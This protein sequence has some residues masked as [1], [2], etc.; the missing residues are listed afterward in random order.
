VSIGRAPLLLI[1]SINSL[2]SSTIVRSA[3]KFVS[4]IF[5]K[6]SILRAV[7]IFPL[8]KVPGSNPNSSPKEALIEGA[9]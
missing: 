4:K 3:V 2:A 8:T 6:P 1:L 7:A 5:L 9:V